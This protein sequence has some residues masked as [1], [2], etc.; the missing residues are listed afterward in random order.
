[1]PLPRRHVPS[2][3]MLSRHTLSRRG[4][5]GGLTGV[6]AATV[7][8]G[9]GAHAVEAPAA[10]R[11]SGY[12]FTLGVASGDPLPNSVV[13]WTR[14]APEPLAPDGHGGMPRRPVA[15]TWQ[16]AHDDRFQRLAASGTATATP[17]LGHS[18]HAEVWGLQ[19]GC[20]YYYRFIVGDDVS[21]T[22]RTKT[23]PDYLGTPG[24]VSLA[25]ASCASWN[26]GFFTAYQHLADENLDVV[27]HLG[28]YIY[29]QGIHEDGPRPEEVP[30]TMRKETVTLARY[31]Q[32][33]G[34]YK[35]D[36]HLKAA[37]AA[38]PWIVTLD[39]HE[40][41]NDW[42]G[43]HAADPAED[44]TFVGRRAAAFQA[45]YEHMPLRATATPHGPDMRLY[46]RLRYGELIDLSVLDT[47]QYRDVQAGG[48]EPEP[49]NEDSADPSRSMLGLDQEKWLL[50]NF[51]QSRARW[52]V[53]AQQAPM[54]RT[55]VADSGGLA[56]F[57]DPWDGYDA[58]R[59]R[60]LD[61]AHDRGANDLV[62]LTGDRHR[63]H[64][65]DLKANYDDPDA[66]T[67]ASELIC[68]SITSG[69][70][71]GD[72]DE[73][74]RAALA[75]NPHM[76]FANARRGYVRCVV[77]PDYWSTDFRVVPAVTEPD[78]PVRTRASFVV[79]HGRPGVQADSAGPPV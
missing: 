10:M 65:S 28:D 27:L 26:D 14:L 73:Y 44:A 5:L 51:A 37:H 34:L 56:V 54:A 6:G 39:D 29:E 71:G 30:A 69:G 70:D 23:A 16:L 63:H 55:N 60:V 57:M 49:P 7:L 59:R 9:T 45:Y 20:E 58:S 32:Q 66:P 36:E 1:M 46:R 64:A 78:A 3:H 75:A 25:F 8:L 47:R 19:P 68:S 53:L 42:A 17:E 43:D 15:V 50:A 61:G 40:V 41:D 18:V 52:Q 74:V 62:V 11:L 31:R 33:Y 4:L 76:H 38:A 13:L 35:S 24:Q 77:T 48:H 12:P 22:G 67:L 21:E 2:W 72:T 79:E